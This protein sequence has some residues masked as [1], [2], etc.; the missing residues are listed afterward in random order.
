MP[1]KMMGITSHGMVL[2]AKNTETKVTE[3][4]D[5]PESCK[6]GD[7]LLPEGVPATWSPFIA[8]AVAELKIWETAVKE[9]KTDSSRTVCFEGKPLVSPT[10]EKFLAPTLAEAEIS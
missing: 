4:I 3:L 1:R 7:R 5:V 10:G 2:C 9:M 6:I 8:E